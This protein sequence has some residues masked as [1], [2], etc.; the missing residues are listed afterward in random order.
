M[1]NKSFSAVNIPLNTNLLGRLKNT[2]LPKT[3]GLMPLFEAVVNSIHSIEESAQNFEDSYIKIKILRNKKFTPF[4]ESD[5]TRK[6]SEHNSEIYGFSVTDNGVGFNDQNLESFQTLDS[7]HKADKGCRGVGRLLWLKAFESIKI[8]SSFKG[9]DGARYTRRFYFNKN[10]GIADIVTNPVEN[11]TPQTTVK[12][13]GFY[14]KY[15]KYTHKTAQ[16][17]ANDLLEHCLW[18]F[19][20]EGGAPKITVEDDKEIISLDSVFEEHMMSKSVT[21]NFEVKDQK[22][23]LTHIKLVS[24]AKNH[25]IAFCAGNRLVKEE[26]IIGKIP[27]LFGRLKEDEKEFVYTG[28]ICSKFLDASVRS[29]RTSFDIEEEMEGLF[30]DSE[31]SLKAIRLEA[32]EKIKSHLEPFLTLN[33]FSGKE[34]LEKFVA[35][36]APRY[37]PILSRLDEESLVVDPAISDKELELSLH[38]HLTEIENRLLADGHDLL[39]PQLG[40]SISQ[41]K[42]RVEEYL[43]VVED[44]KKSDLANYVSHRRVILDLMEQALKIQGNNKYAKEEMIHQLI[45]PMGANSNDLWENDCNLWIIDERLAF[46]NYLA[47]DK[48]LK[49]MPITET[50]ETKEPDILALQVF[51]NPILVNDGKQVPL[52]S[53]TVVEIKRPMR[54]DAAAGE[55]KD[56]IEQAL[57]YLDRVRE[58]KVR[59]ASGRPIPQ[60]KDIPGFCYILCDLTQSVISRC[61]IHG[62]KQTSDSLGYFGYND[63]YKAYIDVYS[64]DRLVNSA[65]ERNRAFFEKLGLPTT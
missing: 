49:S 7:E 18:F 59:T 40:E 20:R 14:E 56:P 38:K 55:E 27:G 39:T 17:I 57:G 30:V 15:L 58:G 65:K 25:T 31:I 10:Q 50:E 52:A 28:F 22:F 36:K 19:V 48:T 32:L 24:S 41:Y 16:S 4:L 12:L 26:N 23:E 33:K 44:I 3:H 51:D 61:R 5:E 60:S 47:S 43:K 9:E 64:F 63:N 46:H 8:I 37:R 42:K 53:I 29:E 1:Q 45:M 35:Q 54:D 6:T 62:L 34:R 2:S 13:E 11:A 21:E